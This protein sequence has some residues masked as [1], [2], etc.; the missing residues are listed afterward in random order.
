M[1]RRTLVNLSRSK[2]RARIAPIN[3]K[4]KPKRAINARKINFKD[5]LFLMNQIYFGCVVF[6]IFGG[7]MYFTMEFI[8]DKIE[9][10]Y[11][12]IKGVPTTK[13]KLET[14]DKEQ[15]ARMKEHREWMKAHDKRME[16]YYSRGNIGDETLDRL[17]KIGYKTDDEDTT[18]ADKSPMVSQ[19]AIK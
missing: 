4:R 18:A 5:T 6:A 12:R 9:T 15:E 17:R 1:L 8:T 14:L 3:Q 11:C 19:P 10:I 13:E 16:K 2:P 7:T